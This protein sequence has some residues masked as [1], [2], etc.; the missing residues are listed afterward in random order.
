MSIESHISQEGIKIQDLNIEQPDNEPNALFDP[1]RDL[2]AGIFGRTQEMLKANHE[3]AKWPDYFRD[4]CNARFIFPQRKHEL[5]PTQEAVSGAKS[6]LEKLKQENKW[7]F[8]IY[9]A[10]DARSASQEYRQEFNPSE[11]EFKKVRDNLYTYIDDSNNA[12]D[13]RFFLDVVI[14]TKTLFPKKKLEDF[15]LDEKWRAWVWS[16]VQKAIKEYR[17]DAY[18]L[19]YEILANAKILFPEKEKELELDNYFTEDE[20]Q[21]YRDSNHRNTNYSGALSIGRSFKILAAKNIDIT[22]DGLVTDLDVPFKESPV[23]LPEI[24]KF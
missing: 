8:F 13:F 10:A 12:V 4:L 7:T 9:Q 21:K 2:P 16:G 11:D 5:E 19:Q 1:R 24:K 15:Y 23:S 18:F 3:Q 6:A 22:E 14:K 17:G 20:M